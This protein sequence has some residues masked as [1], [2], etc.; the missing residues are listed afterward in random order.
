MNTRTL[1]TAF[2]AVIFIACN[3]NESVA[4]DVSTGLSTKGHILSSSDVYITVNEEKTSETTLVYG[5]TFYLNFRDVKGFVKE[6][7]NVF[8]GME[9]YVVSTEGDTAL[10]NADM[11]A[12][13]VNGVDVS[14]L[15][16]Y[17]NITVAKPMMS[18]KEYTLHVKIWDKKGEGTFTAKMNF[19]IVHNEQIQVDNPNKLKYDNIYL[20]SQEKNKTITD[21]KVQWNE[22]VYM[23]FEGLSGFQ[24]DNGK[25]SVGLSV[26]GTDA[27]GEVVIEE[28]DLIGEGEWDDALLREQI[29]ANVV[30][31]DS[32]IATPVKCEFIVWD[33][34]GDAQ[35]KSTANIELQ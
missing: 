13:K 9:I 29:S 34:K 11:Y 12:D 24:T 7:G 35:I 17:T 10:K 1:L 4:V 23:I 28:K 32:A 3:Y 30:F 21:N 20:F 14:P 16:L 15:F 18:N 22:K 5:E 19:D 26:K 25:V 8:P 31:T 6:D 2:L 33:K 27:N